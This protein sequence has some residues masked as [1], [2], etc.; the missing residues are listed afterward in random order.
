MKTAMDSNTIKHKAFLKF[1][2]LYLDDEFSVANEENVVEYP[3][4]LTQLTEVKNL[5]D[6]I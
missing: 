2:N 3:K 1:N 4:F 6:V 5:K